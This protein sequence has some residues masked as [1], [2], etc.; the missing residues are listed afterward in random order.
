MGIAERLAMG[1]EQQNEQRYHSLQVS[2]VIDETADAR[3]LVLKIPPELIARFDYLPGQFL[4][5]RVPCDGKQLVRCYSLSS[6][7]HCDSHLKVTVKRVAE[8]RVSNWFNDNVQ[9]GDLLQV[10]AP[11]GHFHLDD[12]ERPLV[13]FGGGSGITPV[14]SILKSA[15]RISQ[16]PI[17]LIYANRDEPSVIFKDALLQLAKAH[18]EQLQVVH[19]L[20]SLQGYLTPG[21]VRRAVQEHTEA[22]FFICGPG[23]FMD[24][25]E[26]TLLSLDI[27]PQRVHVERFASPPDPDI[28]LAQAHAAL[29]ASAGSATQTLTV[30]LDGQQHDVAYVAGST[31]LQSCKAA[32][33]EVPSS[34]EEG[35]CGACMCQVL[36]GE[37]VLANNN[38]LSAKELADGWTLACQSRPTSARM[39]VKFPD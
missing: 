18:S 3:S 17:K 21:E 11:A 2:E 16:R 9:A 12:S 14:L 8:G 23:P 19:R 27:D 4:T 28:L 10:M 13:L 37:T 39:S 6:S 5:F 25:V 32:G 22:E 7:P 33:L 36:E 30:Q 24:T 26:Q 38:V 1:S 20:D 29:Q 35:F 34:C 31:L 15:L